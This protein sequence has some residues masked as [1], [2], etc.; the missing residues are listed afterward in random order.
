MRDLELQMDLSED[1]S[2]TITDNHTETR[3]KMQSAAIMEE[4]SS[5]VSY[6]QTGDSSKKYAPQI[7]SQDGQST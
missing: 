3:D 1:Q 7:P 6:P 4:Q 2:Q 5:Q